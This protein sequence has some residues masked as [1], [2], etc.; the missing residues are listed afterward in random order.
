MVWVGTN[1]IKFIVLWIFDRLRIICIT[2]DKA[3]VSV[4]KSQADFLKIP[5][6]ISDAHGHDDVTIAAGF[7]GKRTQLA[8]RLLVF[9]L[10]ANRTIGSSSEKIKQVLRVK[11][12]GDWI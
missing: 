2:G 7:V 6:E 8:G 5:G 11:P 12:N 1:L 9:Q 3:V 4:R 10:E